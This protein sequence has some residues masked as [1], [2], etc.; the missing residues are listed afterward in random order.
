[1]AKNKITLVPW[2]KG[3]TP[4]GQKFLQTAEAVYDDWIARGITK[5]LAFGL[6]ACAEVRSHFNAADLYRRL[7]PAAEDEKALD[8]HTQNDAAWEELQSSPEHGLRF[9]LG[10]AQP[11][12]AARALA[13]YWLR[14]DDP[15]DVERAGMLADRWAAQGNLT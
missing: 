9:A 7:K 4:E 8:L 10:A 6:L 11:S 1:M 3:H 2:P 14:V 15:V 5:S 12:S 13:Q